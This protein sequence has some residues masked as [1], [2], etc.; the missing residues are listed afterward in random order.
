MNRSLH[1]LA[2]AALLVAA[3]CKDAAPSAASGYVAGEVPED[4][5]V[6]YSVKASA[7]PAKAGE[8]GTLHLAI[9]PIPGAEVKAETPFRGKL[10]AKGPVRVL[11]DDLAYEDRAREVDGGPVFDI[12]FE[13]GEAGQ[14]SID[15]DLT[16]FV[17]VAEA[18]MR[19]TETVSVPVLVN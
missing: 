11:K 7:D 6:L 17:C 10:A 8:P 12:P 2:A 1:I 13:A 15:A 4:P 5:K 9:Q 16:F 19:T 3:G 18:C 14:G